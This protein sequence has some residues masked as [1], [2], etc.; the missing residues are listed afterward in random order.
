MSESSCVPQHSDR[1]EPRPRDNARLVASTGGL[2]TRGPRRRRPPQSSHSL[3]RQKAP[4]P[5]TEVAP[6]R[7]AGGTLWGFLGVP[8]PVSTFYCR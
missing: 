5:R 6:D 4:L 8:K 3:P 1:T 7:A 2:W